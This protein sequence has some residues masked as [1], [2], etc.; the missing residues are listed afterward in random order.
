M[1]PI[2]SGGTTIVCMNLHGQYHVLVSQYGKLLTIGHPQT[3]SPIGKY[4]H[5]RTIT[6]VAASS[7][8]RPPPQ[9]KRG[10]KLLESLWVGHKEMY[11]VITSEIP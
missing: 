4:G 6:R 5:L 3:S 7:P 11:T 8:Q 1:G 2:S 10:Q 9:T